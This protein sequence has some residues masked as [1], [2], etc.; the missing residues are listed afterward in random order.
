MRTPFVFLCFVIALVNSLQ[1]AEPTFAGE[2]DTTYGRMSLKADGK[3]VSGHYT[4]AGGDMNSVTGTQNGRTLTFTYTEP[5]VTGEGLFTLSAD[6]ASFDGQWRPNGSETWGQWSGRRV[7]AQQRDFSGVW[8]TDYGMM[9]LVQKSGKVEGC[10]N[11]HGR[12]TVTG[13]A[14]DDTLTFTYREPDGTD[15]RGEFKLA[16]DRASFAGTWKPSRGTGGVWKGR[17]VEP[18]AGRVW[19][20]VLEARWESSLREQEY[21]YGEML[22]QFFTRVP[23]VAVRHRFFTGRRDFAQWCAE[24]TY[25]N[26]PVVFYVSSHGTAKG[27]TVGGETLDGSFI[28][29]QL[30]LAPE[31]KLVHLGACLA[32]SGAV[33]EDIRRASGL[34]APVS[35]YTRTADWAGSAVI[36]FAYLDLVLAR[37]LPA[38]EAVKQIKD[39]VA[40]ANE[41]GKAGSALAPAGLKIVD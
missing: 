34:A 14:K 39:S 24:L 25:L 20:V 10:Y 38:A 28:G 3:T 11:F 5:G 13:E 16:A 6:G 12:A 23:T 17:R 30:R 22:R 36:D 8:Q 41:K 19:L 15:G 35:G 33:P 7:Q 4:Y 32:M 27:I 29:E 9:R 31:V 1:A 2:W 21:S 26:E 18:Q 37:K 40:F